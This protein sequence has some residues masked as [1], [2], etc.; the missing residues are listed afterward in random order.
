LGI[1][2]VTIGDSLVNELDELIRTAYTQFCRVS[3]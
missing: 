2:G 1:H 3:T